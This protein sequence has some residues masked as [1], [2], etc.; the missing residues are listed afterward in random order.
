MARFRQRSEINRPVVLLGAALITLIWGASPSSADLIV[1]RGGGELRGKVFPDLEHPNKQ[2]VRLESGGKIP[3]V[4]EKARILKVIPKAGPLDGY[5]ERLDALKLKGQDSAELQFQLGTWCG[6]HKLHDLAEVHYEAAIA[7]D[8]AYAPAH[9]KLGHKKVGERWLNADEQREALGLVKYKGKWMTVAQREAMEARQ[10]A[11]EEYA[12]WVRRLRLLRN[13]MLNA[14]EDKAQRA[15]AQLKEIRE[16]AAVRPLVRVFGRDADELRTLLDQV[17]SL[18]PGPEA[19]SALV[20]RL[21]DESDHQVRSGTLAWL[22]T[23]NDPNIVPALTKALRSKQPEVVNRAAWALAAL[24]VASAVPSLV[25]ALV[26]TQ[27][28]PVVIGSRA[29]PGPID[30]V[31]NAAGMGTGPFYTNGSSIAFLSPPAMAPGSIAFGASSQP[32]TPD[33]AASLSNGA[34]S[35]HSGARGP[36]G[37]RAPLFR[38]VAYSYENVEVHNALVKLSG[39]DFGYDIATWRRW[40]NTKFRIDRAPIRRVPQP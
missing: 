39:Q 32:F 38:L 19:A 14:A 26:V 31:P 20:S 5:V 3:L 12:S 36:G 40:V 35:T 10:E 27:Y 34:M 2:L 30:L 18:I 24:D 29:D 25:S 11:E 22:E 33:L 6:D 17:L 16:P 8:E 23:R 4:F 1:L 28:R 13:V 7:L 15:E 37:G 9:E 21:L